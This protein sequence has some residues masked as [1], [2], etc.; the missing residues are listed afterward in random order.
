MYRKDR[1]RVERRAARASYNLHDAALGV[2]ACIFLL[3]L[4]IALR[5]V[6]A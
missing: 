1:R 5:T 3:G 4:L 6:L 2:A